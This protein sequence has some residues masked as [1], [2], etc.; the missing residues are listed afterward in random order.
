MLKFILSRLWYGVLVMLGVIVIVFVLFQILPGDASRMLIGQ[1]TDISTTEAIKKELGIDQPKFKQ[2]ISYINDMMPVSI[3]NSVDKENFFYLDE[4]KYANYLSILSFKKHKVILKA[5]Y[6]KRSFQTQRPVNEMI[7][8]AF[9]KTFILAVVAMS[10]ALIIGILLGIISAIFKNTF[11]DRTTLVGSVFGMALPSFF[12]AILLAWVFAYLLGNFTH[13]NM[14]GS[15]YTIDDF[16]NGQILT[17]KNLIL[18]ALALG[19]RPL[20]VITELTRASLLDV[21][22]MDYIKTAKAK[23]LSNQRVIF[24]HALKNSLNPVISSSTGWFA[25]MLAGSVFVE[26]VFDWKGMGTLIVDALDK[27]DMPVLMGCIV[28]ISLIL[29]I[30]NIFADILYAIIDPKVKLNE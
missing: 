1:R 3:H 23:G 7:S 4:A 22:S 29:I 8:Q 6:L 26:Y 19:I 14:T 12:F 9:P 21:F 2:L 16:G 5:P 25:S 28:F 17:A 15:L 10:F 13:L 20:A 30:L 27:Y 11:I 18:P 24:K